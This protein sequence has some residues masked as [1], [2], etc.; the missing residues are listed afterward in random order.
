M[1]P[2]AASFV[3]YSG[4]MCILVSPSAPTKAPLHGIDLHIYIYIYYTNNMLKI[5]LDDYVLFEDR[6]KETSKCMHR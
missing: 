5:S 2:T 1:K 4:Y 3:S 6:A